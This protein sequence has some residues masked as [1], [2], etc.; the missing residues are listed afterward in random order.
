MA[1]NDNGILKLFGFEIRRSKEENASNKLQA[2]VPPTDDDGA[3]YVTSAAGHYAQYINMDG[4][5]SK[6]NHQLIIKYRG[7]SMH[8]EVD[9]AIEE[10]VN[11]CI[12]ASELESNVSLSLE[13]VETSDKIKSQ[14]SQEF[15]RIVAML[16][17]NELG[18]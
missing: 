3:G 6:D 14:M 8:P 11:E 5:G 7:V 4:D 18:R 12:T 2:I 13:K 1:E 10:I 17:F 9:T 16:K 15:E